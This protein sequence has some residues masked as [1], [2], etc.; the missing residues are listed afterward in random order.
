[1]NA[2]KMVLPYG[3]SRPTASA[4]PCPECGKGSV[5]SLAKRA[6]VALIAR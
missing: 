2:T 5:Y 6:F 1:M 4:A 3:A